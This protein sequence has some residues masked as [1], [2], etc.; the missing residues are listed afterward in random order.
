[1]VR[2]ISFALLCLVIA[3]A[4][5]AEEY[6]PKTGD[7]VDWNKVFGTKGVLEQ[8]EDFS[9]VIERRNIKDRNDWK[10]EPAEDKAAAGKEVPAEE[11]QAR[12]PDEARP[13]AQDKPEI[14]YRI[15]GGEPEEAGAAV[16][17]EPAEPAASSEPEESAVMEPEEAQGPEAGEPEKLPEKAVKDVPVRK[18]PQK[19]AAEAQLADS[20]EQ[21]E[22]R[23]RV[24]SVT[25]RPE[26]VK[27]PAPK[28]QRL[29]S[30][31]TIRHF[32]ELAFFHR[33]DR[34]EF[35][36]GGARP[37][38]KVLTRWEDDLKVS[39]KGDAS[40]KEM[41]MLRDV[42]KEM[43]RTVSAVS[44]LSVGMAEGEANVRV[45]FLP[46]RK[47][48]DISGYVRNTYAG[49][50]IVGSDVVFYSGRADKADMLRQFMHVL[51]FMGLRDGGQGSIMT[52]GAGKVPHADLPELDEKALKILYRTG[53]EPGMQLDEA[54]KILTG[55][56]TY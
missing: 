19:P 45:F 50:G 25:P 24:A 15:G 46:A 1:M 22:P 6:T 9:Q 48:E 14:R 52:S 23:P 7:R 10:R 39:A 17:R 4:A 43:N 44:G 13:A 36:R 2:V 41:A 33:D 53:F 12:V 49:P 42:V 56:Y 37:K 5:G 8:E 40:E 27:E 30:E 20:E 35:K 26:P 21:D 38:A 51:G 47:G 54:E 18:E 32:L 16:S 34:L 3:F 11:R 29:Y 55:A 31:D 28:P